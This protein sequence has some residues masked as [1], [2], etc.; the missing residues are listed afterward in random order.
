MEF[1]PATLTGSETGAKV[2]TIEKKIARDG[3]GFWAAELK[4]PKAFIGFVGLNAP[5]ASIF[6]LYGNWMAIGIRLLGTR[7]CSGG[8]ACGSGIW[9]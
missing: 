4:E 8:C 2:T 5:S 6:S 7:I 9:I 3:F 1:F